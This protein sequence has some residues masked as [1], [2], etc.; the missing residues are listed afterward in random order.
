MSNSH[1]FHAFFYVTKLEES[2]QFYKQI[3][4][5]PL[6]R[7]DNNTFTIDFFG[8]G[9]SF[10]YSSTLVELPQWMTCSAKDVDGR[11]YV[12]SMH[13]GINLESRELFDQVLERLQNSQI[14]VEF[15]VPPTKYNDKKNNEQSLFFVKDPTGY[16]LEFRYMCRPFKLN[17]LG[18]WDQRSEGHVRAEV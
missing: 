2:I 13:W 6:I 9:I 14:P 10:E 12:P 17:E 5:C 16:V 15:V 8:H 4:G 11:Q 7:S 18:E 1:P 3:L